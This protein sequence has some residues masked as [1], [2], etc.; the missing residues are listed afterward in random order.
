[1]QF[2]ERKITQHPSE[3]HTHTPTRIPYVA[4]FVRKQIDSV[5]SLHAARKLLMAVSDGTL[6]T[7]A[8]NPNEGAKYYSIGDAVYVKVAFKSYVLS[9]RGNKP[10]ETQQK[11]H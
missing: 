4:H 5:E 10:L 8:R 2:Y 9:G 1:M 11:P 3:L 7:S 6:V